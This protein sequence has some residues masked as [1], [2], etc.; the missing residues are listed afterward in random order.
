MRSDLLLTDKRG[1]TNIEEQFADLHC[2]LTCPFP[3][4]ETRF[5]KPL[6]PLLLLMIAF[7]PC[8]K[9]PPHLTPN[10]IQLLMASSLGQYRINSSSAKNTFIQTIK[11]R[12]M[13]MLMPLFPKILFV[14]F[15]TLFTAIY[16]CSAQELY[17]VN[18]P[19]KIW[20]DKEIELRYRPN[21]TDFVITNG[22][23]LFT[24][25]CM[26]RILLSG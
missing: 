8:K 4:K 26:A 5:M 10:L 17:P 3:Q 22:N 1:M 11:V 23:R 18:L 13:R 6:Y 7:G 25:A 20:H 12:C 19:H 16:H 2:L 9:E 24:E 21:G 15:I 14:L